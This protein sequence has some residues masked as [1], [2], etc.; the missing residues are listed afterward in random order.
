VVINPGEKALLERFGRLVKDREI[1]EPGLHV[2]LPWP[3]DQTYRYQTEQIQTLIIGKAPGHE[4]HDEEDATVLWTVTHHKEE[5]FRLLVASRE[6]NLATNATEV[7]AKAGSTNEAS[8][9]KSPPV[10]LLGVGIPV[11]YQITNILDWAYNYNDSEKLLEKVSTREV[12]HYLVN[13]DLNEIMSSARFEA[14]DELRR[15]IQAEADQ[16]KLGV[17]ILLVGMADVHPPVQVAASFESVVAAR[18]KG[19]AEVLAAQAYAVR[20]NSWAESEALNTER[21]AEAQRMRLASDAGARAALFTNQVPAY[22]VAPEVYT[23]RSYLQSLV[24]ASSQTKKVVLATTNVQNVI[25]L[26]LEEKY[27]PDLIDLTM[28]EKKK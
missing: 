4:T 2:K 20:T 13:A 25:T 28:P 8:G 10:N 7:P 17:K 27:R 16:L 9:R 26:N 21:T 15:R 6:T 12:V 19:K 1:L 22:K 24:K 5:E 18:H 23:E 14:G 11:Q 3:I